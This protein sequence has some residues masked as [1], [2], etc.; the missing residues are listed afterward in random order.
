MSG[1]EISGN[2]ATKDGGGVY[3][4]I[5][6]ISG[7]ANNGPA[8]T[9]SDGK[10]SSNTANLGG[11]VYISS[12]GGFDRRGGIISGNTATNAGNDVYPD[13]I[14]DG[15]SGGNDGASNGNNNGSSSGNDGSSKGDNGV[16]I[17]GFSLRDI[18]ITCVITIVVVYAVL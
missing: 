2:K 5:S 15:L 13:N 4:G 11:G 18:L 12:S 14:G 1:G 9:M 8:F 17:G 7:D 3:V 6:F 10:I 16:S